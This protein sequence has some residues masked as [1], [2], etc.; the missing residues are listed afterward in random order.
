MQESAVQMTLAPA[1]TLSSTTQYEVSNLKSSLVALAL[2]NCINSDHVHFQTEIV[3]T[4]GVSIPESI[5][6]NS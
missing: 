5:W 2:I 1:Y 6:P 3:L 4:I